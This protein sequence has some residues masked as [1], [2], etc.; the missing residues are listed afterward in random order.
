M[1]TFHEQA[2]AILASFDLPSEAMQ[3]IAN[4]IADV[5]QQ[6]QTNGLV[7]GDVAPAFTLP[8]HDGQNLSLEKAL[9]RGPVVL[10]FFRGAWCPFCSLQMRLMQEIKPAIN[11]LGASI[12]AINPQS[13][14]SVHAFAEINELS[15]PL[16]CDADQSVIADYNLQFVP[17]EAYKK[18][19][20]AIGLDV[21]T[22]NANKSWNL[23]VPAVY[24]INT[25]GIIMK[26]FVEADYTQRVEP[27][28]IIAE[29]QA[30]VEK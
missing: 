10:T 27:A 20:C 18:L 16:L 7:A 24:I 5:K 2:Q 19:A 12:I 29:L 4:T 1:T 8:N 30:L 25:S 23:P 11:E 22:F 3:I 28:A 15:F 17:I 13:Q 9:E 14:E 26:A 6:T 21:S